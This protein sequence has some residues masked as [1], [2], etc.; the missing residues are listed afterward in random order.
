MRIETEGLKRSI[1]CKDIR[2]GTVFIYKGKTYFKC[3][4]NVAVDL[5]KGNILSADDWDEC[6]MYPGASLRLGNGWSGNV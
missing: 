6:Y 4:N 1:R 3:E 2:P 5:V